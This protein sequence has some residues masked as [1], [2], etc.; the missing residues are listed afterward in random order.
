LLQGLADGALAALVRWFSESLKPDPD[1]SDPRCIPR[2]E[3]AI[4]ACLDA[5]EKETWDKDFLIGEISVACLLGYLDL[6]FAQLD[7]RGAH[8]GLAAWFAGM[9]SRPSMQATRHVL[10]PP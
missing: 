5:L 6:R 4:A 3:A 2:F 9:E 8:P 7:W 10:P 1:L